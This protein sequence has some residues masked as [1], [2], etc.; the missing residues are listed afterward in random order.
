MIYVFGVFK[1]RVLHYMYSISRDLNKKNHSIF[2]HIQFLFM[3]AC[4]RALPIFQSCE[5]RAYFAYQPGII[6]LC[7]SFSLFC[8][9]STKMVRCLAF[10]LGEA[11]SP[12]VFWNSPPKPRQSLDTSSSLGLFV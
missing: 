5:I 1:S 3:E 9:Y 4:V 2:F 11:S 6:M 10:N 7:S 8:L 12:P